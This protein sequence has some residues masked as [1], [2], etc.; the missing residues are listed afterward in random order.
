MQEVWRPTFNHEM[1]SLRT[2]A[3]YSNVGRTEGQEE[4][5]TMVTN[6]ETSPLQTSY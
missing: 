2:K 6:L 4:P 5:E 3:Y 1:T